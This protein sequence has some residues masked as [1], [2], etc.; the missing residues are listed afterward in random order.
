[1]TS[2]RVISKGSE[3]TREN[4]N[5]IFSNNSLKTVSLSFSINDKLE[6]EVA[7]PETELPDCL[8]I[9]GFVS[10]SNAAGDFTREKFKVIDANTQE[11]KFKYDAEKHTGWGSKRGTIFFKVCADETGWRL[12][13]GG[14]R[15]QELSV[16]LNGGFVPLYASGDGNLD[17]GNI[18]VKNLADAGDYVITVVYNASVGFMKLKIEGAVYEWPELPPLKT[19]WYY[20]DIK[21]SDLGAAETFNIL[22]NK[23]DNYGD[24]EQSANIEGLSVNTNIYW[25]DCWQEPDVSGSVLHGV[26]NPSNREDN[27]EV[28]PADGYIRIY[29]YSAFSEPGNLNLHYWT[30][31]KPVFA[32][33]WP[34]ARM[35]EFQ[36]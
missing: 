9:V 13:F 23:E 32:T 18:V 5:I 19:G 22:F 27:P 2:F 16:S 33:K 20:Y 24:I 15:E 29:F 17:P 14:K 10:E 1:M 25:Y 34:G 8:W 12:N 3:A 11:F 36:P 28:T 7:C 35:I 30:D 6:A 4:E 26:S 31:G 21:K